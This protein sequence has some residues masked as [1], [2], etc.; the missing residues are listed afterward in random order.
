MSDL[1]QQA[2]SGA[3]WLAISQIIQPAWEFVV[4]IVLARMLTPKDFG[5]VAM[6]IIFFSLASAISNMGISNVLIQKNKLEQID[7]KTSLTIAVFSSGI[8]FFSLVLVSYFVNSFFNEPLA[9]EVLRVFSFNFIIGGVAMIPAAIMTKE[10]R[11]RAI[12]IIDI[13]SSVIYGFSALLMAYMGYGLWSLVYPVLLSALFRCVASCI[14]AS[15]IPK[16]GWHNK[17]A[18][19]I[20]KFGGGLTVASVL[21]YTARNLDFFIIGRF[22]GSAQLGLYKRAYD[23]AVIPKEKVADSLSRVLLPFLCKIRDD[24]VWTKSAFLKTNKTIAL[25]CIPVLLFSFLS[26]PEIVSVLYG[27]QWTG[28]IRSFQIMSL[29]GI[30]YAL[31]VPFGS[32]LVAFGKTRSYLLL[33]TVYS[34]LLLV[35]TLVGVKYGIEG[36]SLGVVTT[37]FVVLNV[38][39]YFVKNVIALSLI[40]FICNLLLPLLI[41]IS[42][43]IV[44]VSSHAFLALTSNIIKLAINT[45]L[46]TSTYVCFMLFYKDALLDELKIT[47]LD[48]FRVVASTFKV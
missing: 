3:S 23:L 39:V 2:K 14:V 47:I 19:H 36:V 13:L 17:T 7:I 32:V 26:A 29:G 28:A 16:L 41:G 48:K 45:V 24:T 4:G 31:F 22:L 43:V 21:N 6:G 5:I 42:I 27:D 10:M 37:L 11:F 20:F 40:D 25:V 44:L 33:Q 38:S 1:S 18:V 46:A 8:I 35:F 12:S 15:Y 9:G 30:F 34:A